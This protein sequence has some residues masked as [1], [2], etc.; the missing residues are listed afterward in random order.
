MLRVKNAD[1]VISFVNL[2]RLIGLLGM[3]LPLVCFLGGA[4][5]AHLALQPSISSYYYT[6]VRDVFV[7]I[8]V[9]VSMFLISYRG[10]EA[11]DDLV[12]TVTGITGLG[13]ALFPCIVTSSSIQIV[14]FFQ[15]QSAVS[16]IFHMTSAGIFFF[17][18]AMNSIFIFTLTDSK[19]HRTRNKKI[20]N[21]IYVACGVI[22]L[23]ALA[24]LGILNLVLTPEQ[25][26]NT[27]VVFILETVLLEA[28]GISWL[29]KGQTILQD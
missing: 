25:L 24:C 16:N 27:P 4:L 11:I 15:L 19:G 23:A 26:N 17:M 8:M 10:Y 14:G 29:V 18:L 6:N 21:A 9:G 1:P 3:L 20:R 12:S 13:I 7:G 2:R 5:F 28:F 22:I